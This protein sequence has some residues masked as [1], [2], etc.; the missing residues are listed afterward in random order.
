MDDLAVV[1]YT[2]AMQE[3][4]EFI[5]FVVMGHGGIGGGAD[6]ARVPG[7]D[8]TKRGGRDPG[9]HA[10]AVDGDVR[11][12]MGG[13]EVGGSADERRG[14]VVQIAGQY[15]VDECHI[16]QFRL[17]SESSEVPSPCIFL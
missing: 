9:E 11:R 6:K 5:S 14:N 16:P 3:E 13:E 2:M 1:S 15:I 8:S 7:H 4:D 17:T 10:V 12:L